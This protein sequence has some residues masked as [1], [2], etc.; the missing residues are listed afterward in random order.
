MDNG[1]VTPATRRTDLLRQ[2]VAIL[3]AVAQRDN[4]NPVDAMLPD[5]WRNDPLE[6]TKDLDGNLYNFCKSA[7]YW[8]SPDV[9][10]NNPRD[11]PRWK[12]FAT[13]RPIMKYIVNNAATDL[14]GDDAADRTFCN[15]GSLF[16]GMT[17]CPRSATYTPTTGLEIGNMNFQIQNL[18][19]AA[20]LGIQ[21]PV[22]DAQS[23]YYNGQLTLDP[24]P[25]QGVAAASQSTTL[26]ARININ[27]KTLYFPWPLPLVKNITLIGKDLEAAAVLG[28]TLNTFNNFFF[29]LNEFALGGAALGDAEGLLTSQAVGAPAGSGELYFG[30]NN[31]ILDGLAGAAGAAGHPAVSGVKNFPNLNSS[32]CFSALFN[33]ITNNDLYDYSNVNNIQKLVIQFLYFKHV[34]FK[35]I[36]F[37]G[38]GDIQQE[39]SSVCKYGGYLPT[40]YWTSNDVLS[41]LKATIQ[42]WQTRLCVGGDRPSGVRSAV[43]LLEGMMDQINMLAMVGYYA[44]DGRVDAFIV[45]RPEVNWANRAWV[46]AGAIPPITFVGGKLKR[47]NR[48]TRKHKKI[49]KTKKNMKMRKGMKTRVRGI[50]IKRMKQKVPRKR[51]TKK[52]K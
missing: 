24:P 3:R 20:A 37:K 44:G 30:P 25:L 42:G 6:L 23:M 28:S 29:S 15:P 52:V 50:P 39:I 45:K 31:R 9:P 41:Y 5:A 22:A 12:M 46:N 33:R 1:A 14:S 18:A 36:L 16:D 7:R 34:I 32:Y 13:A 8:P 11:T 48:K 38:S 27:L 47:Q 10:A 35:D 49:V 40:G 51:I 4:L 21:G 26:G 19:A 17:Y 2:Q 43:E